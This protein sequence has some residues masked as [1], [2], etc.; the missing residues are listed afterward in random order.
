MKKVVEKI[1][2]RYIPTGQYLDVDGNDPCAGSLSDDID[3]V[4]STTD[5]SI[6]RMLDYVDV[7]YSEE[8]EKDLKNPANYER[9]VVTVTYE[10]KQI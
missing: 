9:V 10:E 8:P 7:W 3:L 2:Y 6:G 5:M 4:N 1:F